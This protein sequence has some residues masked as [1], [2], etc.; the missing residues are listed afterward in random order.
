VGEPRPRNTVSDSHAATELTFQQFL[1]SL[2]TLLQLFP[3]NATILVVSCQK[4]PVPLF[5]WLLGS[6]LDVQGHVV[7]SFEQYL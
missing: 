2:K 1:V 3:M 7:V 5:S 4:V 6:D